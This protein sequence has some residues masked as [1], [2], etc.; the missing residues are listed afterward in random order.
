MWLIFVLWVLGRCVQSIISPPYLLPEDHPRYNGP[1][2]PEQAQDIEYSENDPSIP[3]YMEILFSPGSS[4]FVLAAMMFC[5]RM[6]IIMSY[7]FWYPAVFHPI[8]QEIAEATYQYCG[9]AYELKVVTWG[10]VNPFVWFVPFSL[11]HHQYLLSLA[12]A[13]RSILEFWWLALELRALI[14]WPVTGPSLKE[15][16]IKTAK[17][18]WAFSAM[19]FAFVFAISLLPWGWLPDVLYNCVL[20]VISTILLSR[21]I[22]MF[23]NLVQRT[24]ALQLGWRMPGVIPGVNVTEVDMNRQ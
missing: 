10:S 14:R 7:I 23:R 11:L 5:P 13:A 8:A 6:L 19:N 12:F 1:I 3:N 20:L 18:L 4:I 15:H 21:S 17:E 9:F 16:L 24:N 2:A 22:V